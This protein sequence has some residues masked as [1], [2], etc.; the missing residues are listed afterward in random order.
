MHYKHDEGEGEEEK[1][2]EEKKKKGGKGGGGG[3]EKE[4]KGRGKRRRR[5][6]GRRKIGGVMRENKFLTVSEGT[7]NLQV[8]IFPNYAAMPARPSGKGKLVAR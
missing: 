6:R 4:G 2:K 3:E 1:K 8:L 7:E 5:R